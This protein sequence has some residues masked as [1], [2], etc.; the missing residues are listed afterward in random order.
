MRRIYTTQ[1]TLECIYVYRKAAKNQ[2]EQIVLVHIKQ[3]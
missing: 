3:Q 2:L 1:E